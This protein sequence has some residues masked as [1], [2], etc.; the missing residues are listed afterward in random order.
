MKTSPPRWAQYFFRW[1]CHPAYYEDLQGDLEELYEERVRQAGT[2]QAKWKYMRD[3]LLLF[4]PAIIRPFSTSSITNPAMFRNYLKVST[5]NLL[6]YKSYALLNILGLAIGITATIFLLLI[7]RY[8]QSFDTFHSDHDQVYR[9][10]EYHEMGGKGDVLYKTKSPVAPT[11]AE[12]YAEVVAYTRF[13]SPENMR[14]RYQDQTINPQ[15]HYVDSG[16]AQLFDFGLISGDIVYSLKTRDQIVL[17][18]STAESLFGQED[19][20]GKILGV[21]NKE[22]QFVVGAVVADP[23]DN[24]SLQFQALLPWLN[25]P[26]WLA[27]DQA[28]DWYNTFME[29]Y[30]KLTPTANAPGLEEALIAFRDKYFVDPEANQTHITLLPL[31]KLRGEETQ[32]ASIMTLLGIIAVITL[33]IA[34]VNFTNLS[35]AQSLLRSREIGLRKSL[36]SLRSQLV[37]QFLAESLLTCLLALVLGVLLVH[38]LLPWFNQ[39]FDL[40]L[41]FHYWQNLSLLL[42]LL[43]IG[44]GTGLLAGLYPALFVSRMNPVRS[45]KGD[46]KHQASGRYLQ[47]GLIVLQYAASILLIAG[48][49]VI[50]RQ[51]Q[52]MKN[53]DLHFNKDH[54]VALSLWYSN[55][56][57]QSEEQ[58][59]S[60]IQTIIPRLEKETAITSLAFAEKVPGQYNYNYNDFY[61]IDHPT[62]PPVNIRK[63]T[64]A[65]N[66]FK[67][68]DIEIVLGRAFSPELASDSTAVIIN[69]TAMKQLG[70]TDLEGKFLLEGG[71]NAEEEMRHPVVG[72]VKDYHYQSLKDEIEPLLHYYYGGDAYYS[73]QL[74]VRLQP[75]RISDGLAALEQ[76]YESLNP[77]EPFDYFYSF[78]DQE[79]DQMYKSQE[80]LGLTA[81]LFAGIA[82]VLASLGLLG[83][84]SFATRQRRK[85][86]GVRKV[87][88]AS[89]LQIIVLLSRNF[90]LLVLLAFLIACPLVYYAA[91]QFLQDF[92]YRAPI[93][94]DIFVIA[95]IAAIL[96]AGFSVSLQA[97]RAASVNPVH[98]LR[99]E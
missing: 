60:A 78:V 19:P 4:R 92:A 83:L 91:D 93:R 54:V 65:D 43:G 20:I 45:L 13:F 66:Y 11:M 82:V 7:V 10:G 76:A 21:V 12:D 5:R 95:G 49:L 34:C 70:W 56:D 86:V 25:T 80:R 24:S 14:L 17:T 41:T 22:L 50:W 64:V 87:L 53:Q 62:E 99:N 67:T 15:V 73:S 27:P 97:F 32:N 58:A 40:P 74:A 38:L 51:I 46:G 57:F 84:A 1:Y 44:I 69:E 88:G 72:V 77:H 8:E 37:V 6:K 2:R 31:E 98:S 35:T 28:G 30:V 52:Y 9:I 75:E 3:V 90:A 61:D 47:K 26:E 68:F 96:I 36:G 81:T 16:F 39:Y 42:W 63:T 48:T 29:A 94:I 18:Q 79:F 85:E 33:A 55:F 71:N 59:I 89:V 23:P